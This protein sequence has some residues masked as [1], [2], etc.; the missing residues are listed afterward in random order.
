MNIS[1]IYLQDNFTPNVVEDQFRRK[2]IGVEI[3]L[4]EGE[5]LD[6]AKETGEQYIRDYIQANTTFHSPIF[7]TQSQPP[8][9]SVLPSI[10]VFRGEDQSLEEQIMSCTER[11]VLESYKFI[12]KKDPIL[13]VAYDKRMDELCELWQVPQ[14]NRSYI[15]KTKQ[16]QP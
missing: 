10:Q 6:E 5:S 2:V 15:L 1:K 4:N 7:E 11:K 3:T 12:A 16:L 8:E 13:S 9:P 14:K